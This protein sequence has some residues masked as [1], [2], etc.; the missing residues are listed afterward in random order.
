M[1]VR[2]WDDCR[3]RVASVEK[4]GDMA[5]LPA[6]ASPHVLLQSTLD[7]MQSKVFRAA[8]IGGFFLGMLYTPLLA[9]KS[10][11]PSFNRNEFLTKLTHSTSLLQKGVSW[12]GTIAVYVDSLGA[13]SNIVVDHKGEPAE[14][15][16]AVNDSLFVPSIRTALASTRFSPARDSGRKVAGL[17]SF[18]IT[19]IVPERNAVKPDIRMSDIKSGTLPPHLSAAAT[20]PDL[21]EATWDK[22][23][24]YRSI[25]YPNLAIRANIQGTVVLTVLVDATGEIKTLEVK[26]SPHPLL[27]EAAL[28]AVYKVHFAP[29]RVKGK[30]VASWIQLDVNFKLE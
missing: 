14:A 2:Y 26:E 11:G 12:K 23:E 20:V 7:T 15:K 22:V 21:Q 3:C 17:V 13:I 16:H 29:A 30:P 4:I 28:E 5:I 1:S 24:L 8:A 10:R 27:L 9:Q 6:S 25:R 19:I 18:S